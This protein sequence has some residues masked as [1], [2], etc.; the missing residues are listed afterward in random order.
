MQTY[1]SIIPGG[2]TL[3]RVLPL[4]AAEGRKEAL[5]P[6]SARHRLKAIRWYEDHGRNASLTARHFGFSR[7]TF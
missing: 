2:P 3:A 7:S 5:L 6:A 1:G 4:Q